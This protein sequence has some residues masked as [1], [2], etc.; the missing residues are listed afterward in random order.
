M[1]LTS[2]RLGQLLALFQQCRLPITALAQSSSLHLA[3]EWSGGLLL[4]VCQGGDDLLIAVKWLSG[5][6]LWL[7]CASWSG[8]LVSLS[9][10]E[11]LVVTSSAAGALQSLR[12]VIDVRLWDHA[13]CD[14]RQL[15]GT[16]CRAAHAENNMWALAVI[17]QYT[18]KGC[19][20]NVMAVALLTSSIIG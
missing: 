20:V 4:D 16:S 17:I 1:P 12:L 9:S 7:M 3:V 14:V 8:S 11:C 2:Y 15:V 6:L 19:L 5:I 13:V 10:C 18:R